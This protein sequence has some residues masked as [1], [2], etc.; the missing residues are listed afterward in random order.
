MTSIENITNKYDSNID[1]KYFDLLIRRFYT[2]LRFDQVN[3]IITEERILKEFK[4]LYIKH[5]FDSLGNK[6]KEIYETQYNYV[7]LIKKQYKDKYGT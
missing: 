6:F 4:H 7:Q 3:E 1:G 5:A 2:E